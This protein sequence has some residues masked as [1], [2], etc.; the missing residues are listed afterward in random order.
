MLDKIQKY[1]TD[2]SAPIYIIGMFVFISLVGALI[3]ATPFS[4]NAGQWTPMIDSWFTAVSAVCVTGNVTVNTL[5]HWNYIGRTII[6]ILIEI[7]GLGFM[8]LYV[9][10]F[11]YMGRKINLRLHKILL[12]SLNIS[13]ISEVRSLLRYIMQFSFVVQGLGA[14]LLSLDFIPRLGWL[15][16]IYYAVFHSVSAFCNAGFDLFGDSM[17]SFQDKP[18]VM[19]TIISLVVIGGM[20]FIVWRDL[21][22][23]RRNKKILFHTKIVIT[24]TITLILGGMVLFAI[25][26]RNA[27]LFQDQSPVMRWINY[28]FLSV[29]PRT[30]GFANVDYT[31]LSPAGIFITLVL[32]F[33]GAS[34]GSTGGGI[35][36]TTL[37]SLLILASASIRRKGT[38]VFKRAISMEAMLKSVFILLSGMVLIFGV[39]MILLL[40]ETIPQGF[41]IEYILVDVVS[42]FSTVGLSMGLTPN[43]SFVGKFI[44]SILMLIGRIGI[45]TVFISVNMDNHPSKITYPHG[46]IMIG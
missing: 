16:G 44:L 45:M 25:T 3:L 11:V 21:L 30:A 2:V 20:G 35:K 22:T 32:M 34:S 1:I 5:E 23:F 6:L 31:W 28:L 39:S 18:L 29:T 7:G 27:G 12:E 15:K 33:V 40:T 13:D 42:C 46:N 26:E 8:T 4:S 9:T 41:G 37:A 38:V 17:I 24:M 19:L 43:L 10:L 14:V 36:T